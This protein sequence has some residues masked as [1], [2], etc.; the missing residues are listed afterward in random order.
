[1]ARKRALPAVS[2]TLR[3]VSLRSPGGRLR[4]KSNKTAPPARLRAPLP[5]RPH[6]AGAWPS[7]KRQGGVTAAAYS[8]HV[9]LPRGAARVRVAVEPASQ[10][11]LSLAYHDVPASASSASQAVSDRLRRVVH[12]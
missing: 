1:M 9:L 5:P 3:S 10:A 11:W 7:Q 2:C 6:A 12:A 8:A 4:R